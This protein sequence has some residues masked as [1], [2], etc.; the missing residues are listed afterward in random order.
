MKVKLED[1]KEIINDI[2]EDIIGFYIR[3]G[4]RRGFSV[5]FF[6]RKW[7]GVRVRDW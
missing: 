6:I 1:I 4:W 3:F 7:G 2:S 5:W